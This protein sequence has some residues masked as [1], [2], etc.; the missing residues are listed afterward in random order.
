MASGRWLAGG[1]SAIEFWAERGVG[2]GAGGASAMEFWVE[3]GEEG[4]EAGGSGGSPCDDG[5]AAMT[6][7]VARRP[8]SYIGRR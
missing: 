8:S 7:Q 3:M 4:G 1:A 6:K 2:G 5:E